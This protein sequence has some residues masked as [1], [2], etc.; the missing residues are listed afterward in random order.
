LTDRPD[1][2]IPIE[3]LDDLPDDHH[4]VPSKKVLSKDIDRG[5]H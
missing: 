3:T 2:K 5:V 1:F 4:R